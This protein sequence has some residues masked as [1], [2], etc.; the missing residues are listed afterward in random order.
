[1]EAVIQRFGLT[2][3]V[4]DVKFV[5][6]LSKKMGWTLEK[7]KIATKEEKENPLYDE[8]RSAFKD[9]KL[10]MD[11]KKP[12]KSLDELINELRNTNN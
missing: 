5:K 3:P 12:K 9:V 6:T 2:L 8:L 11:G 7:A 10:M 1:M 4:D